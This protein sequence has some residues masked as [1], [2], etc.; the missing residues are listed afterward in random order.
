[1]DHLNAGDRLYLPDTTHPIR[2]L[3]YEYASAQPLSVALPDSVRREGRAML[4]AVLEDARKL[5]PSVEVVTVPMPDSVLTNRDVFCQSARKADYALVIAPEFDGILERYARWA[6]DAGCRLLGPS[7]QAIALTSDKWGL[8]QH[9]LEHGVPTPST[10]APGK[11][12]EPVGKYLC[13]HRWGAGS[14]GLHWWHPGDDI[15][16]DHLVQEYVAG[17]SV[18]IALLITY[19]GHAMPLHPA[20]Q[21]ISSDGCFRYLGG[22]L[23]MDQHLGTR[24]KQLAYQAVKG[25]AGLQGYVGIDAVLGMATDGSEDKVLEINPRLTTSYLGLRQACR[26]NLVQSMVEAVICD[27]KFHISWGTDMVNWFS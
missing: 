9:W 25:I 5:S 21:H 16:H 26:L 12:P 3:I 15:P 24:L 6:E 4:N 1:M 17:Q 11:V 2:L 19:S 13:K 20:M 27:R 22:S 8:H 23:L 7:P 10:R 18:S 14:L